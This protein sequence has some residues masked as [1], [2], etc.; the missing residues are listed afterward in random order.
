M[1]DFSNSHPRE[2]DVYLEA[3]EFEDPGKRANFLDRA[4]DGDEH[5]RSRVDTLLRIVGRKRL[6]KPDWRVRE[7]MERL[8]KVKAL[9]E[10]ESRK[11]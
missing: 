10:M 1:S 5:L 9:S 4:C 11:C 7:A 3:V 2:R 6:L 8:V